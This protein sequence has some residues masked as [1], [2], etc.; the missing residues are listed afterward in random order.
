MSTQTDLPLSTILNG[1]DDGIVSLDEN[2]Q[3]IFL[4]PAAEKFFNRPAESLLG[5]A[6][7]QSEF[8]DFFSRLRL[9]DLKPVQGQFRAVHFIERDFAGGQ[10]TLVEAV[11]T[12]FEECGSVYYAIGIRF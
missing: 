5:Q 11:V 1:L 4:N 3:I 2:F 10:P 9:S 8:A 6:V 12:C 7:T